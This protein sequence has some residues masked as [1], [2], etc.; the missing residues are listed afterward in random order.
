MKLEGTKKMTLE[1]KTPPSHVV[2]SC[3]IATLQCSIFAQCSTS[4]DGEGHAS[5]MYVIYFIEI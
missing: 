4:G 5:R 2:E 3:K 1:I